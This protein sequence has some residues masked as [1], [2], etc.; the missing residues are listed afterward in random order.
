M[1]VNGESFD[2]GQPPP[3]LLGELIDRLGLDQAVLVAE[4]DGRVVRRADFAAT[5][6]GEA[7]VVELVRFV[8]GG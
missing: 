4:V 5:P 6:L 7:S 1:R 8:G 3:K 2:D